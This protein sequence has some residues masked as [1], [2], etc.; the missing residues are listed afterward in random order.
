MILRQIGNLLIDR[1]IRSKGCLL[2]VVGEDSCNTTMLT[3]GNLATAAV[4]VLTRCILLPGAYA[5]VSRNTDA[6]S[7][8][9]NNIR[10]AGAY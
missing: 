4:K 8:M 3:N 2:Q 6:R 10:I 5:L 1:L 7:G 9:H